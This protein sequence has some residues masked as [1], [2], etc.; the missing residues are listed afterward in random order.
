MVGDVIFLVGGENLFPLQILALDL[1][2][3]VCVRA[4]L[5]VIQDCFRRDGATLLFEK[6]GKRIRGEGRSD[7]GNHIGND[8]FE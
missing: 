2:E 7:V 6:L 3:E 8:A 5:E 4:I 1:I